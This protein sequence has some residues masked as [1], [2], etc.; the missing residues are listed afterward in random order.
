MARATAPEDLAMILRHEAAHID[1]RDPEATLLIGLIGALFWPN[2]AMRGLINRWRLAAEMRAD[3]AAIGDLREARRIAYARL[4][5]TALRNGRAAT[6]GAPS[7]AL[8]LDQ[9]G[10]V[11]LRLAAILDMNGPRGATP[12]VLAGAAGLALAAVGALGCAVI[13]QAAPERRVALAA[14]ESAAARPRASWDLL[15]GLSRDELTPVCESGERVR[16]RAIHI[17]CLGARAR[18]TDELLGA[19]VAFMSS[20]GFLYYGDLS[21]ED[22]DAARAKLES[23]RDAIAALLDAPSAGERRQALEM[24]RSALE[25]EL[26]DWEV[27]G[28]AARANEEAES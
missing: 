26:A 20:S 8:R 2:P 25:R 22:L 13:A 12:R 7:A 18:G 19:P 4:L 1:R 17:S 10:A 15:A 21:A 28:W 9:K 14:A 11:K 3:A 6:S 23:Q 5:V 27:A 24:Q 16:A